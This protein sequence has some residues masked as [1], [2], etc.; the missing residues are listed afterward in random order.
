[1]ASERDLL[2]LFFLTFNCAKTPVDVNVFARH[3]RRALVQR[4]Q[5][6]QRYEGE[7]SVEGE[8]WTEGTGLDGAEAELGDG[9]P[10]LVVL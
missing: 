6:Q 10:D 8:E 1:M 4:G 5:R 9:L 7:V 3:L 2:D